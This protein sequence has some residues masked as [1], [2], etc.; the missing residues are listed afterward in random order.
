MQALRQTSVTG[1]LAFA[2]ARA[3]RPAKH[4]QEVG[5]AIEAIVRQLH[6]PR[7]HGQSA[8]VRLRIG[9]LVD[10]VIQHLGVQALRIVAAE[11]RLVFRIELIRDRAE[12]IRLRLANRAD[13]IL[14]VESVPNEV[15]RQ[16]FKQLGIHRWVGLTHV[17]FRLH[18]AAAEEV[19]P[20]AVHQ[21]VRKE[22]ISR[23]REPVHQRVA[24]IVI[25]RQVQRRVA[26]AGS[27]DRSAI[28]LV[29]SLSH[30]ARVVDH[31]LARITARLAADRGEEGA[32]AV[33]ILLA[34][35]LKRMM[36]ALG[37]LHAG[38]EEQLR[39]ILH[40]RLHGLHLAIPCGGGVLA[41]V[42]GG[43]EYGAGKLIVT[44]VLVQAI[45]DPAVEGVVTSHGGGA[46]AL[47]AQERAP[48]VG[49][50]IRVIRAR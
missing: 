35:F 37:A 47:V 1:A 44:Y 48:F 33:V 30:L 3:V 20:V 19:F 13:Q 29:G 2:G 39:G 12:L 38:A 9:H 49:K 10:G 23:L 41:H 16:A 27:L 8:E 11:V 22:L 18:Q 40:L 25:G 43:G 31:F 50:I 32:E 21:C 45:A 5:L 34:P 24:G 14:H 17:I 6:C 7:A 46:A 28:L 15:L 42:P 26:E 4:R 36:V